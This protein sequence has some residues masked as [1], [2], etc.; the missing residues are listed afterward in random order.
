MRGVM[1]K[2]KPISTAGQIHIAMQAF[3]AGKAVRGKQTWMDRLSI[4]LKGGVW[5]G[6]FT[7]LM[8]VACI[9]TL[10]LGG[11]DVPEGIRWIYGTV[12]GA[13]A[14]TKTISRFVNGKNGAP[15]DED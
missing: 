2:D 14:T 15:V 6:L 11:T 12:L 9:H 7:L 10:F 3:A 13:F 1:K 5:V 8:L 4:N